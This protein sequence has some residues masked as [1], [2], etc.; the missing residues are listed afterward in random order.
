MAGDLLVR[1][2]AYLLQGSFEMIRHDAGDD[3]PVGQRRIGPSMGQ[4]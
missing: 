3:H 2:Q 4:C 1:G